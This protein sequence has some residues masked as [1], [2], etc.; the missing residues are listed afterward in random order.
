MKKQHWEVV[1]F[2]D[3][4]NALFAIW[5]RVRMAEWYQAKQKEKKLLPSSHVW[6]SIWNVCFDFKA[7]HAKIHNNKQ[8]QRKQNQTYSTYVCKEKKGL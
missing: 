2:I 3:I 6:L 4:D 7:L 8:Q 5:I 1:N